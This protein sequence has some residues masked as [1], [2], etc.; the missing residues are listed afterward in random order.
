MMRSMQRPVLSSSPPEAFR[1]RSDTYG[2]DRRKVHPAR[3]KM[4]LVAARVTRG[5]AAPPDPDT[6]GGRV[7][8][9]H[10]HC[11]QGLSLYLEFQERDDGEEE[12]GDGDPA[13]RE[14]LDRFLEGD[15]DGFRR[16]RFKFLPVCTV[17]NWMIRGLMGRPAI[18]ARALDTTFRRGPSFLLVTV[19]VVGSRVASSI[20]GRVAGPLRSLVLDMGFVLEAS[21]AEL[22]ERLIGGCRLDRVDLDDL[23]RA[24]L[25]ADFE[26]PSDDEHG[27]EHGDKHGDG[28]GGGRGGRDQGRDQGRDL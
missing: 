10:F 14:L 26:D 9:V 22:P 27:D 6:S 11:P 24:D 7:L 8:A 18:M 3:S 17:G 21:G 2:F 25:Y 13:W 1:V 28:R 16:R 20:F 23:E 12:G 19:D 5:A 4:E 15:D